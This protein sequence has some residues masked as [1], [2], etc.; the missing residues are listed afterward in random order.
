MGYVLE[1]QGDTTGLM[2]AFVRGYIH[3][4]AAP[5]CGETRV[6]HLLSRN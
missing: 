5:V 6:L 3:D 2:N 4:A 1:D